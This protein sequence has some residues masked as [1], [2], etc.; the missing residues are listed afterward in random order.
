MM[1]GQLSR[2]ERRWRYQ[3]RVSL[4]GAVRVSMLDGGKRTFKS[5]PSFM[6][7][8]L[9]VR[10]PAGRIRVLFSEQYVENPS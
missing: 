4:Y 10:N 8:S 1:N 9:L 7:S 6:L 5:M 2:V 3:Q